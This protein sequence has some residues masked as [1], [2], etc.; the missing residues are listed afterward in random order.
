MWEPPAVSVE[1][2]VVVSHA[3]RPHRRALARLHMRY[4]ENKLQI[5]T[6][7]RASHT[8]LESEALNTQPKTPVSSLKTE[9]H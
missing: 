8:G 9:Y 3:A 5:Y 2:R 7:G 6:Q 1:E 4:H